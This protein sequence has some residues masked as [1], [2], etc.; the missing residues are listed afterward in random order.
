MKVSRKPRVVVR[1]QPLPRGY[2]KLLLSMGADRSSSPIHVCSRS[3]SLSDINKHQNR[4]N[5]PPK[6]CLNEEEEDFLRQNNNKIRVPWLCEQWAS[7]RGA[8][9]M[10]CTTTGWRLPI[11]T[12]SLREAAFKFGRF[13]SMLN[14]AS[15]F[16]GLLIN[17]LV[18]LGHV[19]SLLQY[20]FVLLFLSFLYWLM[21]FPFLVE[22]MVSLPTSFYIKT[23][24]RFSHFSEFVTLSWIYRVF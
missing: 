8:G 4:L 3:L 19:N 2:C 9:G 22:L 12:A 21:H 14:S 6:P 15:S 7:S 18:I 1:P 11:P 23:K 16:T 5:I 10:F 20:F 13:D 17:E 24:I